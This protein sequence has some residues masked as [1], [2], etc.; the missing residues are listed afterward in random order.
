[1]KRPITIISSISSF[2][3]IVA[4]IWFAMGIYSDKKNGTHAADA[5]FDALL[6]ST[7]QAF[8]SHPYGTPEF[9]NLFIKAIGNIEDFSSLKLEINGELVYAYPPSVFSLPSPQLVKNYKE[10]V[11]AETTGQVVLSASIYLMTPGSI[12]NHSRV[13]FLLIL[14]G[15]IIAFV[16]ILLLSGNEKD[17]PLP[18]RPS[19]KSTSQK[20]VSHM[21]PPSP[22]E[23]PEDSRETQHQ[24]EDTPAPIEET[25]I[26]FDDEPAFHDDEDDSDD[27]DD[28]Q[29]SPKEQHI[30]SKSAEPASHDEALPFPVQ[31]EDDALSP[32]E[33]EPI[34]NPEESTNG[35]F[36][37]IALPDDEDT[38]DSDTADEDGG[39]DIIDQFEQENRELSTNED[40]TKPFSFDEPEVDATISPITG[41]HLQSALTHTLDDA[42]A[43]L[44]QTDSDITISLVKINGLDRGNSLSNKV[45]AIIQQTTDIDTQLFEYNSDSYALITKDSDLNKAVEISERLYNNLSDYLKDN[46]A[47]NEVSIGISSVSKRNITAERILLEADQALIH[48]SQ[49]PDSPIIAFRANP[50]KYREYMNGN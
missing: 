19:T 26:T 29:K 31:I 38:E 13:A 40:E 30:E 15:T 4:I 32:F 36:R 41:I 2:L 1:M 8:Q 6:H 39:L 49:D 46:N 45:I 12:Y 7:Q 14:A 10:L 33:A 27:E 18:L 48:A 25:V 47:T 34:F 24:E 37:E 16:L 11:P 44:A 3:F 5:R 17:S 35:T 22:K 21:V 28:D 50:D 42:I 23:A 20:S 43:S 9:S